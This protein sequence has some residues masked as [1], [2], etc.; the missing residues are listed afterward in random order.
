MPNDL[1]RLASAQEWQQLQ[2]ELTMRCPSV[3]ELTEALRTAVYLENLEV[4]A[5][6]LEAGADPNRCFDGSERPAMCTAVEQT[7]QPGLELLISHGGDVNVREYGGWT[8]LIHAIDIELTSAAQTGLDE[9]PSLELLRFLL[10]HGANPQLRDD[11]GQSAVDLAQKY[12]WAEAV[13]LL[14]ERMTGV[15]AAHLAD[16]P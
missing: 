8:L 2:A 9:L 7:W 13:E 16:T 14:T 3:E 6:L 12:G 5:R 10:D 15:R 11:R 4:T 1:A